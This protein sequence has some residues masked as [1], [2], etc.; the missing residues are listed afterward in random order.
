[1]AFVVR[2]ELFRR[3]SAN[4]V[5]TFLFIAPVIG[6]VFGHW[7]LGEPLTWTVG[8]GGAIVSLGV[9]LVYRYTL[10]YNESCKS[11]HSC[12]II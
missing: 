2:A 7:F 9:L 5:S 8:L 4:T 6:V 1:M 3:Y 11:D 10:S 12:S